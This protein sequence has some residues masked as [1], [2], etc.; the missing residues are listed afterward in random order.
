MS[1]YRRLCAVLAVSIA[2]FGCTSTPSTPSHPADPRP[3]ASS[4]SPRPATAEPTSGTAQLR[5]SSLPIVGHELRRAPV[6]FALIAGDVAIAQDWQPARLYRYDRE[7][8]ASLGTVDLGSVAGQFPP[9]GQSVALG[10]DGVWITLAAQHAVALVDP[11]TGKVTRRIE[12]DGAPYNV[13]EDDR[14]LWIAD[15]EGSHV[16]R[17][18]LGSGR[19]TAVIPV[20]DPTGIAVGEGAVW[21]TVHVGR[22]DKAESIEGHGGQLARIDPATNGV[23]LFDIGPRPYWVVTGFGS[24]WTGSATGG[25]VYRVDATTDAVSRIPVGADGAFDIRRVGDAI[26]VAVGPQHWSPECDPRSTEP[27][28]GILRIDPSLGRVTARL[29]AA[30]AGSIVPADRRLW[31]SAIPG[32]DGSVLIDPEG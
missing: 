23:T 24:A 18:D 5:I 4:A 6:G 12:V 3:A 30:C 2:V 19:T 20:R 32:S 31:V 7:T 10:R 22:H 14:D 9:D 25:A 29:D 27:T 13:V 28:G 8:F 26:W 11:T 17:V 15:F 16:L 21:A 1:A